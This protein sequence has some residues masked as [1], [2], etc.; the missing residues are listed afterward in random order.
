MQDFASVRAESHRQ[1]D[2]SSKNTN[3]SN[4][5]QS[6]YNYQVIERLIA[7]EPHPHSLG[8]LSLFA[9]GAEDNSPIEP[10]AVIEPCRYRPERFSI[11]IKQGKD[12]CWLCPNLR[13]VE[14]KKV[15]SLLQK[16]QVN[17]SLTTEH[18]PAHGEEINAIVKAVIES[19]TGL[20]GAA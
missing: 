7:L 3:T 5:N 11:V 4:C 16:R 13:L 2:Q 6:A 20:G 15:L 9:G 19:E 14:A 12:C 8:Q 10:T 18:S 17:L 1:P